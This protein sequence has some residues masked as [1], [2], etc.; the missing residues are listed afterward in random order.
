MTFSRQ[1][2]NFVPS[3]INGPSS[4]IPCSNHDHISYGYNIKMAEFIQTIRQ[5]FLPFTMYFFLWL[6]C[7]LIHH[8][9]QICWIVY[10]ENFT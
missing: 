7:Q 5:N 1:A 4:I 10:F 3:N 9:S 8:D 6:S 2:H